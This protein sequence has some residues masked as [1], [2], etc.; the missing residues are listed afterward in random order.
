MKKPLSILVFL[1]FAALTNAQGVYDDF[2]Y[3]RDSASIHNA[4]SKYPES[5]NVKLNSISTKIDILMREE[6][7]KQ[8]EKFLAEKKITLNDVDYF[9]QQTNDYKAYLPKAK[10]IVCESINNNDVNDHSKIILYLTYSY[11]QPGKKVFNFR[12]YLVFYLEKETIKSVDISFA[13]LANPNSK[14]L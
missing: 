8:I 13:K 6:K 7:F 5:I 10:F 1:L 11:Q 12:I 4:L 3:T 14:F 2:I 9:R